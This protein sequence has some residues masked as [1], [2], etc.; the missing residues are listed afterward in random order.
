MNLKRNPARAGPGGE[1]NLTPGTERRK[2]LGGIAELAAALPAKGA[3]LGLDV[4]TKT[5]GMAVSDPQRTI[6]SPRDTIRRGRFRDDVETL[7]KLAAADRIAGVVVGLPVNMDGTEGPRCQSV[8]QFAANLLEHLDLPLA[9]WDERL[10]TM[11]V[12]RAML[13]AD[14]SR[15][16]R[17]ELADK[18][19]AAYI[20]QGALD[21]LAQAG[22]Q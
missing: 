15:K 3:L 6:A 12:T 16:R 19:A 8:R 17:A 7:K 2:P 1:A 10:S 22:K 14:L 18:L 20:L 5:V 4:G 21:A 11:A 9:F 13:E